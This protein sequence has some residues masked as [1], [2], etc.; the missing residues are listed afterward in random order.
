[1]NTDN[2]DAPLIGIDFG[3][4]KTMVAKFDRSKQHAFTQQLG[5]CTFPMPTS[6]YVQKNGRI[7]IGD[8]ADDHGES[9]P[10]P[11]YHRRFKLK[12]GIPEHVPD[13]GSYTDLV[14][15]FLT[16]LRQKLKEEVLHQQITRAVITVPAKAFGRAQR[17]ELQR[18]AE[19]AGISQVELLPEPVAAGIAYCNEESVSKA[20]RF[21]VVDW[22]GGTFDVALVEHSESGIVHIVPEFVDGLDGIGE[23]IWMISS[24]S[25]YP[26]SCRATATKRLSRREQ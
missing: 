25:V 17:K 5:R 23:K 12:L 2:S 7:S 8:D 18:A 20:L 14:A 26:N 10:G 11:N 15:E 13:I 1:M 6:V 21:M 16:L 3:T 24:I 22:G 4:T 9:D 19:K